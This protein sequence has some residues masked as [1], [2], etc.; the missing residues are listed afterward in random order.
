[1]EKIRIINYK[2]SKKLVDYDAA[3][4]EMNRQV[5]LIHEKKTPEM[6][7]F[8]E[9][10]P[11]YSAGTSAKQEE[12]LFSNNLP[13]Y[14]SGR[15]GRYTYHG[16]GQRVAYIMINLTN[17]KNDIRQYIKMLEYWIINS[18][19]RIGIEGIIR[20]NRIGIWVKDYNKTEKKE[21]KI[22]SIGIRIRRNITM[23]G[24]SINY[25]PNLKNFNGI[26][27][28]GIKEHGVTSIKELGKKIT[29]E[30]FDDILKDEFQKTFHITLCDNYNS[31]DL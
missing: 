4:Q 20:E 14:T 21:F 15:G 30:K 23:H 22:A 16:P 12:L 8:L 6:L 24:I 31:Q 27:P 11:L 5:S 17:Y 2:H 18:L 19:Q 9:H 26:I 25:N 3:T 7:W 13:I 1:M 28:C 10:P 29:M